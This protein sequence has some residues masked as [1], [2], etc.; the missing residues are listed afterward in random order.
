MLRV[1]ESDVYKEGWRLSEYR[2]RLR[3]FLECFYYQIPAFGEI[4]LA[5]LRLAFRGI[6]TGESD[7]HTLTPPPHWVSFFI[8]LLI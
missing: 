5:A 7:R 6:E 4:N 3:Q 2:S 8:L 1:R